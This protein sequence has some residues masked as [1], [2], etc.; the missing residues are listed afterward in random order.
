M[1]EASLLERLGPLTLEVQG[2]LSNRAAVDPD[3]FRDLLLI[4]YG[5][6]SGDSERFGQVVSQLLT[7]LATGDGL[8]LQFEIKTGAE[9]AGVHAAYAAS[10]ANGLAT[11]YLNANDL[12]VASDAQVRMWLLEEIGHHFDTLLNEGMDSP[13]D[14]GELFA[15]L[16][17]GKALSPLE[18][19]AIST[20]DDHITLTLDGQQLV[21]EASA[22]SVVITGFTDD[23]PL[24]TGTYT[25][26]LTLTNDK[27]PTINFTYSTDTGSTNRYIHLWAKSSTTQQLVGTLF[28]SQTSA[29]AVSGSLTPSFD[30]QSDTYTFWTTVDGSAS[31]TT[32]TSTPPAGSFQMVIDATAPA[33]PTLTL[34]SDSGSKSNDGVTNNG[35]LNVTGLESGSTWE[36][37]TNSGTSWT[38][39][40][41]T[42]FT[43]STGSYAASVVR[44]RQ[45]DE[46]GNSATRS[47]GAYTIDVTPPATPTFALDA[48]TGSSNNDGI[49]KN[50]IINV[51]GLE[52]GASWQYS[53]DSGVSWTAGSGGSFLLYPGTYSAGEV[54]VRQS[55]LAGNACATPSQNTEAFTIDTVAPTPSFSLANDTGS[56]SSDR[57]TNNGLV[58]VSGLESGATWEYST[59]SGNNWTAG[60]G[61]SF[62]LNSGSYAA[63]Q[64]RLRQTDLAGNTTNLRQSDLSGNTTIVLDEIIPGYRTTDSLGT[65]TSLGG[66][67]NTN[68]S[69]SFGFS[70]DTSS[71][72]L[73]DALGFASQ[74]NWAQNSSSY[75]VSLWSF[76]GS[77]SSPDDY[78]QLAS[79]VFTPGNTYSYKDNYFWQAITPITL[80]DSSSD[81]ASNQQGYI[82]SV[83]GDFSAST[84]N[85]QYEVGIPTFDPRFILGEAVYNDQTDTENF[86]PVPV[87]SPLD[88]DIPNDSLVP[89][90][91]Q[92]LGYFNPNLSF[93][94]AAIVVDNTSPAAPSFALASDAGASSTDGISNN[95]LITVSGIETA[96]S[97][98][99]STNSGGS[100]TAGS[101]TSFTLAAGNYAA[102]TVQV[103]QT[104]LAG[105][106]TATPSQSAAAIT[107]DLTP[108]LAPSFALA[109]DTGSSS[110]D[111][112]TSNGLVT[113]SGIE[114]AASWEYSTNSGGSWTTGSDTSFTLAAGSYA[115]GAVQVRQTDLAGN[116][117]TTPSQNAAAISIDL[118][119]P[120]AP[121]VALASDAGASN[122]DGITNNGLLN[123]S[124]IE[125][126][127]SW[128][129][130]TNGGGS[131]T[132][133][134]GTSFT[135]AAGSYAAG[136]IQ[137]R[138]TDLA[139]NT[140][141]TPSQSA[142][143][144]SI[145]LTPPAAP[146]FAL[147]SDTGSSPSDG[148]TSNGLVTVSGVETAASWEYSTN[149]GGSWT[150]GSGTSF[151]L[152]AGNYAAGTVQVRQTDLAGNTTT[153]PSQNAGAITI[154]TTPP[155][156]P[157]IAL[158]SDAGT[159]NSDGISNNGLLNVSGIETGASWEYSL[160]SGGSWTTGSGTTFTLAA[161]SY[162]AGV[163]RV[164]QTDLAG[165]TTTTPSQNAGAIT[166]DTTPPTATA[167]IVLIESDT[168]TNNGDFIT[169]DTTLTV[170]G[171][172]ETLGASELVQIS[173]NGTTWANVSQETDSWTF[174][175]PTVHTS[176]VTYQVRVTDVA[177][178]V[179][180][181]A[182]QL[183]TIDTQA[184]TNLAA[185]TNVSTSG[186][187]SIGNN[188]STNSASQL[189]VEG[190]LTGPL[191]AGES[192]RVYDGA[193]QLGSATPSGSGWTFTDNRTL[194]AN[195]VV[196]Y[197]ARVADV[198]GNQ[199]AAGSPYTISVIIP[200][201]PAISVSSISFVEG[202]SGTSTVNFVVALSTSS[203]QTVSVNYAFRQGTGSG[204][205]NAADYNVSSNTGSL[206]F[207]PGILSRTVSLTVNG[208]TVVEPDEAL[209]LDLTSPSS[210]SVLS[211]NVSTLTATG[212]ILN[213][214]TNPNQGITITS[215]GN[216][217]GSA[218]DD[219][220]T[221]DGLANQI[222]GLAGNDTITGLGGADILSGGAGADVF[223]Y[224][225]FS[226][227]TSAS[228]DQLTDFSST[229]GDLIAVSSLPTAVWNAGNLG[230]TSTITLAG[231]MQSAF[232]DK[233]RVT[234]GNQAL[235]TGEAVTFSWSDGL[236]RYNYLA[237]A[238]GNTS[239]LSD[240]LLVRLPSSSFPANLTT[241]NISSS[242]SLFTGI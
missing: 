61:T 219:S 109:S 192:I 107:V 8:G 138:Q 45:I 85:V 180:N 86:Y 80:S 183:V 11:I 94:P 31:I 56:S 241:G 168:G 5:A 119:P 44:V 42:S 111:G 238:D 233:N 163:I 29:S 64:I 47:A 26:T 154:D 225:S 20:E 6:T 134:S 55:D 136:T 32:T 102:G 79:V 41:G 224:T 76:D 143:A 103:R 21:A 72:V 133:G 215:G 217:S 97:W 235:A 160:N 204:F 237:I 201:T 159:S 87:Y 173:S 33:A 30:F 214:D 84:G 222:Q 74:P 113:V 57:V 156:A 23:V 211:G 169:S 220:L 66:S 104:D 50:T 197:S 208:D 189:T 140:T 3:G 65:P 209:F 10:G 234:S 89:G 122:S 210:N 115:A 186:G 22:S 221:G 7:A 239:N 73:I 191:G 130:S 70:F 148:I 35:Q 40:S 16:F 9:L 14:E 203:S 179:G 60:T 182:S 77:G 228:M 75:T 195:Q 212:T 223:R 175:D 185:V 99:Y 196:R 230:S 158:A 155:A 83:T 194:A 216:F 242:L 2:Q 51:S 15:N 178:N 229:Q 62:S 181:T 142:A 146:S 202:N 226:D 129:Y 19:A 132:A 93:R 17:S 144:I 218:K 176:N 24:Y 193:L 147:V 88:P 152:A 161:G 90:Y 18:H 240:D 206:I 125:T 184:P 131:W 110:S 139:G 199:S 205:A 25:N 190:S 232:T 177:G 101:G 37:S 59:D 188:Q 36:Y 96:A 127:A 165:N 68:V 170:S 48:D 100:W 231:A 39:G 227:S 213:D 54:Q 95:G 164:R 153:T 114:T 105:N 166:I 121:T 112:I 98:E 53:T 120:A 12:D 27:K 106:T 1:T 157:T 69:S 198:A 92:Y 63:G 91:P 135:L 149:S 118:T 126:G 172:N 141:T 52:A 150:T 187:T 151:T 71:D 123:V 67:T 58:N 167:S 108:P 200:V 38:V 34:S 46:A 162:A 78:D 81:D 13:G 4:V 236:R 28:T 49:T 145:D 43:L 116:V 207:N 124:G 137:V 128:E 171:T 174:T 82:V 117:T